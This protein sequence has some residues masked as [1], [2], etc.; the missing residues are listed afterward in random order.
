MLLYDPKKNVFF[1]DIIGIKLSFEE[2]K[3]HPKAKTDEQ[4]GAFTGCSALVEVL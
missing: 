2:K 3:Q 4:T 1:G